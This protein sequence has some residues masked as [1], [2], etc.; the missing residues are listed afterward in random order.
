M[1]IIMW[2][3]TTINYNTQ[4]FRFQ[5]IQSQKTAYRQRCIQTL[6]QNPYFRRRVRRRSQLKMYT[7]VDDYL[8]AS[9][10]CVL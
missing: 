1:I 3:W 2:F 9:F 10:G 4:T 7:M 5:S 8:I 6:Q